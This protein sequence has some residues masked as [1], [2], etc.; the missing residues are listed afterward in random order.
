MGMETMNEYTIRR[1]LF[2]PYEV[3]V[4]ADDLAEAEQTAKDLCEAGL[5]EP[6][7]DLAFWSEQS[8]VINKEKINA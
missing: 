4:F 3:V 2:V 1:Y 6:K 8:K 7:E 5:V